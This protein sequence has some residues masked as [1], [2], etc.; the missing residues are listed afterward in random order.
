[1]HQMVIKMFLLEIYQHWNCNCFRFSVKH[2]CSN[3]FDSNLVS[4]CPLKNIGHHFFFIGGAG[5]KDVCLKSM[6]LWLEGWSNSLSDILS[7]TVMDW[8]FQT[9]YFNRLLGSLS[10]RNGLWTHPVSYFSQKAL[11]FLTDSSNS[12]FF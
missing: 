8:P 9:H 10:L 1:M 11:N 12:T 3:L 2:I 4:K 6:I 7:L 5:V